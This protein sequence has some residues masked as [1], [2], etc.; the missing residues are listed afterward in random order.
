MASA[1]RLRIFRRRVNHGWMGGPAEVSLHQ[2]CQITSSAD[3]SN[4]KRLEYRSTGCS[5]GEFRYADSRRR[6][7]QEGRDPRYGG[8]EYEF[9]CR[10]TGGIENRDGIPGMEGKSTNSVAEELAELRIETDSAQ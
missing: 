5:T 4:I 10:E 9:S 7:E 3:N 1:G 6:T 8:K 2:Q